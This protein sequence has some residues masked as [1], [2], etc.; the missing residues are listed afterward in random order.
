MK[1][2]I[3]IDDFCSYAQSEK[4]MGLAESRPHLERPHF[5]FIAD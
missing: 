1:R 2:F 5:A 3:A 4:R